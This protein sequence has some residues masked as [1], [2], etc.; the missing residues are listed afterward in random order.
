MT[1]LAVT[2]EIVQQF[3]RVIGII[4]QRFA[5]VFCASAFFFVMAVPH[6]DSAGIKHYVTT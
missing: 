2:K 6:R 4:G 5:E 3:W 1:Q